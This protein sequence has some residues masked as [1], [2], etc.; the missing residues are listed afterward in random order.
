MN[1]RNR[2]KDTRSSTRIPLKHGDEFR[3]S[4]RVSIF[5]STR[6]V[7]DR[8]IML[9][10]IAKQMAQRRT[11]HRIYAEILPAKKTI[12]LQIVLNNYAYTGMLCDCIQWSPL[13]S[14]RCLNNCSTIQ[15]TTH[16][17][18]ALLCLLG[19]ILYI[20]NIYLR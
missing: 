5:C 6:R 17:F 13:E 7:T 4:G 9:H 14:K 12:S 1:K 20:Y 19:D 8:N 16:M 18:C 3:C 15:Y 10:I 11:E 2:T